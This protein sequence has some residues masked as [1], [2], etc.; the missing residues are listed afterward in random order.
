[1]TCSPFAIACQEWP[2]LNLLALTGKRPVETN[3]S[4][5][6]SQPQAPGYRHRWAKSSIAYDVGVALGFN[7]LLAIDV[8]TDDAAQIRAVISV[9]PPIRAAKRGR[10]GFTVFFQDPTG[11]SAN[12]PPAASG[13]PCARHANR[14]AAIRAPRHGP[15]LHLARSGSVERV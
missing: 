13:N 10:R 9:L 15:A 2:D 11:D 8:D 14:I 12:R 4:R 7:G 1:M 6:C 3:W 5:W